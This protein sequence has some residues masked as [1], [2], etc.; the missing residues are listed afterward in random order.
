MK[1]IDL[2]TVLDAAKDIVAARVVIMLTLAM[3]F[4]LFCW[5]LWLETVIGLVT[6]GVFAVVVFLPVLFKGRSKGDSSD[7]QV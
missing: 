6:A 7:G 3:T 4:A 2:L 5:A 1:Q